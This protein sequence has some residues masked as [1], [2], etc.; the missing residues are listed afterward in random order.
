MFIGRLAKL[1]GC[2]P[3]AIR[4]YEQLG[5]INEPQREGRYRLYNAH[6]LQIV[7]LIRKA[8]VAGFKLA[9]MGPLIA[10]KN[11]LKAFPLALANEA[12]DLKRQQVQEKIAQLQALDL[13][14]VA[15][16]GEMNAL[17][18]VAGKRTPTAM[19]LQAAEG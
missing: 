15:L 4:L 3:K 7:H 12:V 9:E 8:Q 19:P 18:D 5:L 2:T 6:H 17:F 10:A 11:R 13:H 16:K 1:T 14:L